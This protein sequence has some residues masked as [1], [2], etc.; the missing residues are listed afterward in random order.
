MHPAGQPAVTHWSFRG[1][2]TE[3]QVIDSSTLK[4]DSH[5]AVAANNFFTLVMGQFIVFRF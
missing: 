4:R 2:L 5:F 1:Q 3:D